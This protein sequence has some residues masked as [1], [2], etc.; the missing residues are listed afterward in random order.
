MGTKHVVNKIVRIVLLV[1]VGIAMLLYALG[2]VVNAFGL[3]D[4]RSSD[5]KILQRLRQSSDDHAVVRTITVGD[6][7][8]AY[9]G[10][11]IG[12]TT[13]AVA[14]FFVHGFPGSLDACLDY[15]ANPH[16]QSHAALYTYDRIGYGESRPHHA[17]GSLAKQSAQLAALI[18]Y[19]GARRNI[20]VGHSLGCSIA[21]YLAMDHPEM[22]DGIVLVAAPLDPSL[23]PSTW[24]RPILDYPIIRF[25]VARPLRI[26]NREL[27]PLKEELEQCL[28]QWGKVHCPVTLIHGDKDNL[29]PVQNVEFGKRVMKNADVH[30]IMVKGGS[31]FIM[32]SREDLISDAIVD[33]INTFTKQ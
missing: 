20:L 19:V 1:L 4:F 27:D 12:D 21:A 3:L 29:V 28:P 26:S 8:I 33:M 16:L 9:A 31:H 10:V 2:V 17:E 11:N 32:W 23:E 18:N 15:L 14:V 13:P 6:L 25:A 7:R 22:V 30:V 24:W 5:K